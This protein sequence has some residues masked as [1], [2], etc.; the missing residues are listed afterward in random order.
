M[1]KKY[2]KILA[3]LVGFSTSSIA[4]AKE[5][6]WQNFLQGVQF[7]LEAKGMD[8]SSFTKAMEGV[9]APDVKV[10]KK[11]KKQPES[12]FTFES[13]RTR[14]V[15]ANRIKTG[16]SKLKKY[17]DNFAATEEK[18]DVS[19][20][21]VT[22][23]WGIES[24]FGA[25]QGNFKIIPSLATLAY[26]SHRKDFF[27]KELI[28][29]VKI[30]NEGHISLDKFTG[31]WAGA[32]GQC[33]FMPSS[34]Y[35]FGADGNADGK[36]DIWQEEADVFASASNYL[37]MS[38]WRSDMNWGE[39]VTLTKYLPKIKLSERGLSDPK[40]LSDWYAMGIA[41]KYMPPKKWRQETR[42][43]RLFMPDGPSERSYLVYENF[44]VIMK[45][46]RSSYFAFSVLNL[47][48][49]LAGK[50]DL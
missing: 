29:A 28:N 1:F 4:M 45:W 24:V 40:P 11:L 7:E 6:K 12:V 41:H 14:M 19:R 30:V 35:R 44:D 50:K 26:N 17:A 3:I 20:Y 9:A 31:S 49:R 43:A 25:K 36:I 13:Y 16:Q 15:N 39:A 34:F 21:V 5:E 48:D 46:N 22:S 38:G 32:M 8:A 42:M 37:R 23:L 2:S 33:Q 27:R 18:Y 47:A 10:G